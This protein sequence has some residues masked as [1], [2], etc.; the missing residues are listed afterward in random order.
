MES[1]PVLSYED[2]LAEWANKQSWFPF[3]SVTSGNITNRK[4]ITPGG[5]FIEV[6][7]ER[8]GNQSIVK[9]ITNVSDRG[10]DCQ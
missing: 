9:S 2:Q 6:E 3:C 1:Y 10:F 7:L 8:S 4:Y 5:K